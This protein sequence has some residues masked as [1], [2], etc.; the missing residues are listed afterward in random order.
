MK[1]KWMIGLTAAF[2]LAAV[3]SIQADALDDAVVNFDMATAA[4]L[5]GPPYTP[6]F[7]LDQAD[8]SGAPVTAPNFNGFAHSD[9]AYYMWN[10]QSCAEGNE[11]CQPGATSMFIRF[12]VSSFT[13]GDDEITN[14]WGVLD[15]NCEETEDGMALRLTDGKPFFSVIEDGTT[16]ITRATLAD[17][18]ELDT[19]YDL[20]GVYDPAS[21]SLSVILVDPVTNELIN[22]ATETVTFNAIRV[23]PNDGLNMEV[24]AFMAAC[25]DFNVPDAGLLEHAAIWDRALGLDEVV[26]LSGGSLALVVEQSD[27]TTEVA[28]AGATTDDFTVVLKTQPTDTVTVTVDPETADVQVNGA[29]PNNPITLTFT[30]AD[31]D[32]AQ[33]VT[34]QANDDAIPE[35]EETVKILLS[36]TS[37]DPDFVVGATVRVTVIDDDAAGAVVD[38]GD[39][40]SVVEGGTE[41]TYTITLLFAPN[42]DV[43]ITIDDASEPNQVT[44]NGGNEA[45]LT[46]TPGNGLTPQTVTVAAIDDAEPEAEGH[47]ATLTHVGSQPGGDGAYEGFTIAN[48]A[49]SVGENDCG[50]GPFDPEDLDQNCIVDVQDFAIFVGRFLTC[51]IGLCN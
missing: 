20:T 43:T 51:S 21:D 11:Y 30:T 24:H 40:V 13:A 33:G 47:A 5:N 26:E 3:G 39:G 38:E 6:D 1:A 27:G 4:D 44:V 37:T 46:F 32:T 2:M 45:V 16:T 7:P 50:A 35:G 8:V 25:Y 34:V 29:G 12:R 22:S 36:S 41:D 48:V 28:E 31:W 49:V 10:A 23:P 14:L 18:I 17:P 15:G 9:V 19:W 42:S